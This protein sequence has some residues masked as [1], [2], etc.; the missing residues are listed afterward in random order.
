MFPFLERL[1]V[2][3]RFNITFESQKVLMPQ[4]QRISQF[5]ERIKKKVCYEM[6][7]PRVLI[8]LWIFHF[9]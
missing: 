8:L 1:H 9:Y 2:F 3:W 6:E 4:K 7:F 5:I